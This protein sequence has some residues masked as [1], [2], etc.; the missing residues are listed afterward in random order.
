MLES[1]TGGVGPEASTS[2]LGKA[3]TCAVPVLISRKLRCTMQTHLR[4]FSIAIFWQLSG[5]GAV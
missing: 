5:H 2:A 4:Q 1:S 3:P